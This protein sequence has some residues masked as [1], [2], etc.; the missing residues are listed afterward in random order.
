MSIIRF[1][2]PKCPRCGLF[3]TPVDWLAP[4]TILCFPVGFLM[5]IITGRSIVS[6]G[7]KCKACGESFSAVYGERQRD[8]KK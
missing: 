3:E 7:F 1:K 5:T 8:R 6:M 4:A 2:R